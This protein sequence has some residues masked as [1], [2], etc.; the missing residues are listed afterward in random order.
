MMKVEDRTSKE[1]EDTIR[2]HI[3]T[4]LLD[5]QTLAFGLRTHL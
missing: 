2:S 4:H 1:A 5:P 3:T